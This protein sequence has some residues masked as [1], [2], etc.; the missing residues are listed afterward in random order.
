[1]YGDSCRQIWSSSPPARTRLHGLR[2][3]S[4]LKTK[5]QAQPPPCPRLIPPGLERGVLGCHLCPLPENAGLSLQSCPHHLHIL[6]L[7]ECLEPVSGAL[8]ATPTCGSCSWPQ[9]LPLCTSLSTGQ[10]H[11]FQG[12]CSLPP[13]LP[14]VWGPVL[15][16]THGVQSVLRAVRGMKRVPTSLLHQSSHAKVGSRPGSEQPLPPSR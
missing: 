15:C 7:W 10:C 16:G 1:M 5:S 2:A 8:Q 9:P 11:L 6:C 3:V 12:G 4:S 13:D 14:A